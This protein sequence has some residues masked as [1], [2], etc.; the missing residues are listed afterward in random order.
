MLTLK[1]IKIG[2][3]TLKNFSFKVRTW[4]LKNIR[5]LDIFDILGCDIK[6]EYRNNKIFRIISV[7]SFS[8]FFSKFITDVNRFFFESLYFQ[9]V[10][11]PLIRFK[12]YFISITWY[13]LFL[14]LKIYFKIIGIF[15]NKINFFSILGNFLDLKFLVF[16]K[17]FIN[18]LGSNN[19]FNSFFFKNF[20][21]FFDNNVLEKNLKDY[22]NLEKVKFLFF[23][24]NPR[25]EFPALYRLLGKI[26]N[27]IEV[28]N[29]ILNNNIKN[30]D[31]SLGKNTLLFF[32][33]F[34]GNLKIIK[35][36]LKY[37]DKFSII[38]G[39]SFFQ[40]LSLYDFL[41]VKNI[42]EKHRIFFNNLKNYYWLKN[43]LDIYYGLPYLSTVNKQELGF[44]K[45]FLVN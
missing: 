33:F 6:V 17:I 3:L 40:S 30:N 12:N 13:N 28:I 32:K 1:I 16:F 41:I 37:F 18:K 42:L 14:F 31:Y 4:E 19:I 15:Y 35:N 36:L 20:N 25:F 39:V 11:Y 43:S 9:R 38:F 7:K 29:I 2:A 10:E 24:F 27:K 26:K 45:I 23:S 5:S 22:L 21:N 34:F 44:L 8:N